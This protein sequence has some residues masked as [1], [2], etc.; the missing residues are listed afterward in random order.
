MAGRRGGIAPADASVR[1]GRVGSVFVLPLRREVTPTPRA[2]T[3]A[4]AIERT[5]ASP[6]CL[7]LRGAKQPQG[8]SARGQ[9]RQSPAACATMGGGQI[10]GRPAIQSGG[11]RVALA[12]PPDPTRDS[13]SKSR[14]DRSQLAGTG[15]AT[16]ERPARVA[17]FRSWKIVEGRYRPN[18]AAAGANTRGRC[19]VH[20]HSADCCARARCSARFSAASTSVA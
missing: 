8:S 18:A 11:S 3:N 12:E 16:L 14:P 20:R 13:S 10:E 2:R 6:G 19:Q 9:A 5:R 4:A 15:T 1:L 17:D 7:S